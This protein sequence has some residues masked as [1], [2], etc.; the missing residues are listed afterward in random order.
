MDDIEKFEDEGVGFEEFLEVG[1][2]EEKVEIE[3]VEELEEDGEE[4][5]CVSIFKYSFVEEEEESTKVE[6]DVYIKEK[7]EF[8]I[9]GDDRAEEDM[10][11]VV[12]KGEVE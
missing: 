3:E 8:V 5:V 12:E 9:S 10:D 11:E 4:I 7:R 6:V 1:D 2:Y